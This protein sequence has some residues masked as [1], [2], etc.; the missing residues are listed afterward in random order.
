MSTLIPEF[1]R[2]PDAAVLTHSV[3]YPARHQGLLRRMAAVVDGTGRLSDQDE[4][5]LFVCEFWLRKQASR[6]AIRLLMSN[7]KDK[8]IA[9]DYEKAFEGRA[10]QAAEDALT[11]FL[12]GQGPFRPEMRKQ[13]DQ[14][15][16]SDDVPTSIFGAPT[17]ICFSWAELQAVL[18]PISKMI[19][20]RLPVARDL[21]EAVLREVEKWVERE[22]GLREPAKKGGRPRGSFGEIQTIVVQILVAERDPDLPVARLR[23][24]LA[25]RRS[26]EIKAGLVTLR[27][28]GRVVQTTKWGSL[29][30]DL[31]R[32]R[33]AARERL[34]GRN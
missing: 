15:C 8:K 30:D 10:E 12:S 24:L 34:A 4:H 23:E 16:K 9:I 28:Q 3:L 6:G 27:R 2:P 22:A 32:L 7:A 19:H 18:R 11:V 13:H 29:R 31:K 5:R 14:S 1:L 20:E 26:I 25:S 33:D 21:P 17:E